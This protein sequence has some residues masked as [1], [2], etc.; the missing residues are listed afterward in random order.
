MLKRFGL[1]FA[2]GYVLGARGGDR[3]YEQITAAARRV[4]E[5]P[6]VRDLVADGPGSA[7][8]AGRRLMETLRDRFGGDGRDEPDD[9]D[10]AGGEEHEY[11]YEEDDLRDEEDELDEPGEDEGADERGGDR[12]RER[13]GAPRTSRAGTPRQSRQ[14]TG[15]RR[16]KTSGSGGGPDRERRGGGQRGLTRL[17]SAAI[18]RGKVA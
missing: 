6:G 14:G 4:G 2:I 12:G 10:D 8:D 16:R 11:E 5:L 18:E 1:G 13:R 7:R 15:Q 3:H 17:A 9:E